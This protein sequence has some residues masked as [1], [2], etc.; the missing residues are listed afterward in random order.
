[1]YLNE[2]ERLRTKLRERKNVMQIKDKQVRYILWSA[3]VWLL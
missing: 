2:I 1:M 3:W